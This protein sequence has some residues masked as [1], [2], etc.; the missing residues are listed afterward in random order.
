MAGFNHNTRFFKIVKLLLK[1]GLSVLALY[2]VTTKIDIKAV[3]HSISHLSY[4]LLALAAIL[5]IASI[6]VAT[7]RLNTLFKA[8]PLHVS[9]STNFKLYWLGLFYNLFLPGGIGGDGYKVFLI[10][11]YHKKPVKSLIGVILSDRLSGLAVI[12]IYLLILVYPLHLN[13]PYINWV[14]LLIPLVFV[15][16][17]LFLYLF[18]RTL[19]PKYWK[20]LAWSFLSQGIQILVALSILYAIGDVLDYR[21]AEY[22]F[23]FLLSSIMASVPI[24]LGGIGLRELTFMQGAT[25]LGLNVEHAVALSFIFYIL[26]L[27]I[28]LPGI[29]YT[30]DTSKLLESEE[31]LITDEEAE[32]EI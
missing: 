32:N 10:N 22:M 1:V 16:Y 11:K 15:G 29:I 27:L 24:S 4:P 21:G 28:S 14:G 17:W 9:H 6:V 7:F 12:C 2:Y 3:G 25:I 18:N 13:I 19:L 20:V 23:L 26:S 5:L 8:M 30:F 31:T